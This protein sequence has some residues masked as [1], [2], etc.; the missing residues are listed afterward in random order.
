MPRAAS[1]CL[2]CERDQ[3]RFAFNLPNLGSF[4]GALTGLIAVSGAVY[5][6]I[7]LLTTETFGSSQINLR[8]SQCQPDKFIVTAQN[9]G[10]KSAELLSGY[11]FQVIVDDPERVSEML[12]KDAPQSTGSTQIY[13]FERDNRVRGVNTILDLKKVVQ[14]LDLSML[15]DRSDFRKQ[16]DDERISNVQL[17]KSP[18]DL[19]YVTD[20]KEVAFTSEES[21]ATV[22]TRVLTGQLRSASPVAPAVPE[23]PP[24]GQLRPVSSV[25]PANSFTSLVLVPSV[26]GVST[27]FEHLE[28][29]NCFYIVWAKVHNSIPFYARSGASSEVRDICYCQPAADQAG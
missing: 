3:R 1:F 22:A 15:L 9:T 20:V 24:A 14:V 6:A 28:D 21:P 10:T 29:E 12:N 13:P 17:A 27:Q 11:V 4:L 25:I 26:A 7:T 23:Q 19:M 5:G 8:A 18:T 16:P 2:A